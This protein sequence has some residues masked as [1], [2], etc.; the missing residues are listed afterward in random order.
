MDEK[1]LLKSCHRESGA[2]YVVEEF[3]NEEDCKREREVMKKDHPNHLFWCEGFG[4]WPMEDLKT[5]KMGGFW[6]GE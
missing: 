6:V 1:W 2:A 3:D 4:S 5:E